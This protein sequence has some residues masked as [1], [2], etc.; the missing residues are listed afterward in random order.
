MKPYTGDNLLGARRAGEP[1]E[2]A[3]KKRARQDARKV[4][5]GQIDEL[6]SWL[7]NGSEQDYNNRLEEI[8]RLL[9]E[10]ERC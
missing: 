7:H 10:L 4:I 1:R 3:D 2:A 9:Q 8:D 5:Q 6:S